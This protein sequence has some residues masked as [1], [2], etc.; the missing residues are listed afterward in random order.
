MSGS[1]LPRGSYDKS[2]KA[3]AAG[4]TG[5]ADVAGARQTRSAGTTYAGS[6]VDIAA[7]ER[8]VELMRE[9]V[10]GAR[11]AE[12]V[13]DLG[14]FAGLFRLD[15]SRYREP[16]L[17]TATDGVGTKLVIARRLGRHGT[18]GIDLVAMVADD[19]VACGAEPLFLTDYIACGK[20][21]PERIS[22]IVGGVAEGCRRAG[23]AL[24]GGETAEHPDVLDPDEYDLAGAGTGVVEASAVL[25]ADRV[26]VADA[27]IGMAS[28]GLHSN[29]YSLV[30]HVMKARGL[31]LE[32]EYDELGPGTFGE[33]LLTPTRIYALDCLALAAET[34]LRALAHITGGGLAA[35]LERVLPP[36]LDA[37]V[38]R[39]TWTVP[40]IFHLVSGRGEVDP[41]EMERTFNMGIGMVA[42][43]GHDDVD[44]ALAVLMARQ[45]PA[46]VLG[47]VVHGRGEVR[48]TGAHPS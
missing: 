28:S 41:A 10:R 1:P 24:I 40:P 29:G 31:G 9:R 16:L 14:G 33:A 6:G 27:V 8:A 43:V 2:D 18:V 25:G 47:E 46:W 19:L 44:R 11:R 3:G 4:T 23:C 7:G 32:A 38:D 30:R 35:N 22:E 42:V 39:G 5:A 15:L 26:R 17:A 21:R 34:D 36:S 20:V 13:D 37:V 48:L 12:V 45:V